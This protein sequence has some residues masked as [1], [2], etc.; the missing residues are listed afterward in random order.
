MMKKNCLN[1]F[2]TLFTL[3][4]LS[5]LS[6]KKDNATPISVDFLQTENQVFTF[7]NDG[8]KINFFLD[9]LNDKSENF[10]GTWP[11]VDSYR[12]YVDKNSN[13][14]VD[15]GVDLLIGRVDD[16][17]VCVATLNDQVSTSGCSFFDSVTGENQFSSTDN[18][19]EPHVNYSISIPKS[20]L[21]NSSEVDV[22]IWIYNSIVGWERFPSGSPFFEDTYTISW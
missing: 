20:M 5:M 7:E 3:I 8:D 9:I 14:V 10:D 18:L 19:S 6:C 4:C 11:D 15:E 16:G 13:G 17:R 2:G 21:S 1:F 12:I 22:T